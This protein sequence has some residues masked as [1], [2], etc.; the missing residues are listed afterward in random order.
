MKG[1][2]KRSVFLPQNK[3][4]S[5]VRTVEV[6]AVPVPMIPAFWVNRNPH[7]LEVEVLSDIK[8]AGR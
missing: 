6:C 3:N 7:L 8:S 4:S 1:V 2:K 5:N